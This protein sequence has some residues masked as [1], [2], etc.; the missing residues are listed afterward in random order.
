MARG[1]RSTTGQSDS[2]KQAAKERKK[3]CQFCRDL[4]DSVLERKRHERVCPRKVAPET[5][6]CDFCEKTFTQRSTLKNQAG[7]MS[8]KL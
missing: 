8:E 3:V 6:K 2:D 4:L 1:K 7:R 5:H